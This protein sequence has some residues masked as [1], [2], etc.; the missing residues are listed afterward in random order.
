MCTGII[1]R[2]EVDVFPGICALTIIIAGGIGGDLVG[3]SVF[4]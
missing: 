4:Q 2:I 3:E 1:R